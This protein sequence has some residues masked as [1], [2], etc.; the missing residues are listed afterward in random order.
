M[1]FTIISPVFLIMFHEGMIYDTRRDNSSLLDQKHFQKRIDSFCK[2]MK[3]LMPKAFLGVFR[4]TQSFWWKFTEIQAN[5]D[6]FFLKQTFCHFENLKSTMNLII[7]FQYL[8]KNDCNLIKLIAKKNDAE[9][10]EFL[11][12]KNMFTILFAW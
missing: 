8:K 6:F 11:M 9:I 7:C 4:Y 1:K 10:R 12:Q 3:K 2:Q 5:L